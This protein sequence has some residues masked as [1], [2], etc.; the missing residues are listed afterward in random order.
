MAG[1]DGIKRQLD[2]T[3]LGFGP[4]DKN[5]YELTGPEK[6]SIRSVPGS[7]QEA[8]Q[9]LADDHEFLLEGGV[10]TKDFIY[11]WI[12]FKHSTEIAPVQLRPHPYEFQLYLDL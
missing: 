7:L 1:I 2:P 12:E 10:F 3:Q 5:I 9:A 6:A 8:L 4:V 11:N